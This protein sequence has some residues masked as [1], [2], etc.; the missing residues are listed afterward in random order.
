MVVVQLSQWLPMSVDAWIRKSLDWLTRYV[1][2]GSTPHGVLV[3]VG[4]GVSWHGAGT[5]GVVVGVGVHG[6]PLGPTQR[7]AVGVGVSH[8]NPEGSTQGVAVP[9]GVGVH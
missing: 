6:W 7:V 4:V 8:G 5:H 2:H 3:A 1:A 9:V